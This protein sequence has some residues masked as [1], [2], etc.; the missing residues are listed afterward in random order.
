[1]RL[2]VAGS[3]KLDDFMFVL[4]SIDAALIVWGLR[5]ESVSLIISGGARGVDTNAKQIADRLGIDFKEVKPDYATHGRYLAP[6]IRN[7]QMAED[8]ERLVAV[9]KAM[10]SGTSHMIEQMERRKK[11]YIVTEVR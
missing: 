6:L 9:R 2:V 3:R 11:P 1:V 4:E 7:C 5:W 10:S 8:G